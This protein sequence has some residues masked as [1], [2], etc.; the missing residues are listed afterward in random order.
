[1]LSVFALGWLCTLS[2]GSTL[3]EG[4]S[5]AP[6]IGVATA[7]AQLK[8][9]E[10]GGAPEAKKEPSDAASAKPEHGK[11]EAKPG[12][13]GEEKKGLSWFAMA[14]SALAG[15]VLFIYGV[16]QLANGLGDLNS[17]RMR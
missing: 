17:E 9:P 2:L 1:M 5:P 15:L 12:A 11:A 14:M 6:S 16:T 8:A 13:E 7:S 4:T 10:I 3:G